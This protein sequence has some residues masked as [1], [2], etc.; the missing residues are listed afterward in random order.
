MKISTNSYPGTRDFYPKEM[1][2]RMKMFSMIEEAVRSFAYE[3]ISGPLLENFELY[4]AKSGEEIAEQQLY[5]FT[6]KGDRRVAIR[7]EFTPTL[8]RMFSAKIHELPSIQRWYSIENF[9]RYE[10]PQ[11]GRLREFYQVNVDLAGAEGAFADFEIL[12]VTQAVFNI[13]GADSSMY[14]IKINHRGFVQ[15]LITGYAGI[16]LEKLD[17]VCKVLDKKDKI[18]VDK[19]ESMLSEQGLDNEQIKKF[20]EL[21]GN[22]FESNLALAPE[23]EGGIQLKEVLGL[24]RDVF[25]HDNPL[26]YSFSVIRGLAYYTGIVFEAYDKNPDNSRA[27]FGG[28]RYDNLISLFNKNTNVSGVGFGMGDV[29]FEMFLRGHNLL[30]DDIIEKHMIAVDKNAPLSMFHTLSDN[31][32]SMENVFVDCA[33]MLENIILSHAGNKSLMMD[34]VSRISPI[35]AKNPF[36]DKERDGDL[37]DEQDLDAFVNTPKQYSVELYPDTEQNLGK[38]LKYADKAGVSY[39]WICGVPEL[40]KGVIKRKSMAT[41]TE[42]EFDLATFELY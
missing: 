7:P 31:L 20:T 32:K 37:L 15:D 8:A 24:G 22:D 38:Q 21:C 27:L 4:A 1:R 13:F 35:L 17:D 14:D 23:S 36:F 25:K 34:S 3:K 41:S 26:V 30:E 2:F 33:S 5:V 29:T 18:S 19:F 42:E 9:M 28:G 12:R 6:D 39:V 10:R 40:Q 11:K 16:P